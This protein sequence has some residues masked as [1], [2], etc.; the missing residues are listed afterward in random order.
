MHIWKDIEAK[1]P[2][3]VFFVPHIQSYREESNKIEDMLSKDLLTE[4]QTKKYNLTRN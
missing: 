1:N 3:K 2:V 4:I